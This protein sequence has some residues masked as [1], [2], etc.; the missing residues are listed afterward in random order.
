M[1]AAVKTSTGDT[2]NPTEVIAIQTSS[3]DM[4]EC[5]NLYLRTCWIYAVLLDKL[6]NASIKGYSFNRSLLGFK[7][8][9]FPRQI[10]KLFPPQIIL[11]KEE[12][13]VISLFTCP[14]YDISFIFVEAQSSS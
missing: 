12:D 1:I 9:N 13:Y 4:T 8:Q 3:A 14:I 11:D 6:W 5:Q 10:Q 2:R 7:K